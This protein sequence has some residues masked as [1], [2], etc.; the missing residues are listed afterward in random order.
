MLNYIIKQKKLISKLKEFNE[1]SYIPD[2]ILLTSFY[3]LQAPRRND[4][5]N[6]IFTNNRENIIKSRNY[7]LRE[8]GEYIF[9]FN[10][11][12]TSKK[13]GTQEIKVK[14][15]LLKDI[16]NFKNYKEGERIYKKSTQS[17]ANDLKKETKIF[18]GVKLGINDI[19]KLISLQL[20]DSI[21]EIMVNAWEMGHSLEGKIKFYIS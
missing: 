5:W 19:R 20:K 11:F 8:D 9:I 17:V 13:F 21:S 12:K 16:L 10:V 3:F 4:Y 18:F 15:N 1:K 2:S 14:T 6:M 7:L